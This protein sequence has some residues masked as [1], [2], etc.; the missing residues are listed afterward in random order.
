MGAKSQKRANMIMK[1]T[2][3]IKAKEGYGPDDK[4]PKGGKE[5]VIM[6][7]KK[8]KDNDKNAEVQTQEST[9]W[10]IYQRI[11]EKNVV[12]AKAVPPEE[13]TPASTKG[14]HIS[15]AAAEWIKAH[16]G[17]QKPEDYVDAEKILKQNDKD[18]MRTVPGKAKEPK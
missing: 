12:D 2:S 17:N 3:K 15:D 13:M 1:A 8:K 18:L 6:N 10:P 9:K 16:A 11:Q 14:D 5:E 4:A 7:P